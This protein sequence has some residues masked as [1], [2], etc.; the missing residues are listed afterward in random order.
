MRYHTAPRRLLGLGLTLVLMIMAGCLGDP[1]LTPASPKPKAALLETGTFMGN[2]ACAECHSD[3]ARSHGQSSHAQTLSLLSPRDL[4][5]RVPPLGKIAQSEFVLHETAEVFTVAAPALSDQKAPLDLAVG[6]GKTGVTYVAFLD[7]NKMAEFR[8]SYFPIKKSWYITPGQEKL[9]PGSLG[10]VHPVANGKKCMLCHAVAVPETGGKP[11]KRFFGVGC[12]SC[13]GA[14]AAHVAAARS[15][16]FDIGKMESLGKLSATRLNLLCGKC[17]GTRESVK[18]AHLPSDVSNRMQTYG[19]MESKCFQ[20]SSDTLSCLTC[21]SP[22]ENAKSATREPVFY[23]RACLTCHSR[24]T[25]QQKP[26]PIN[27]TAK[28][29]SC[30]MPARKALAGSEI[31]MMMADHNIQ[32][33]K[34]N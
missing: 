14:G 8:M 3:I 1:S 9:V 32:I 22:H 18:E 11:E 19:L 6:S 25:P 29:L 21:H 23:E 17:H 24:Q 15:G 31:P 10:K 16:K 4:G 33:P 28:C 27:P 7:D 13:H 20:K 26:C 30:H 34:K 12:E 5:A 2:A